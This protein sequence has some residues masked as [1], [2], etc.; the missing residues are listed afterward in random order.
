[1]K[2][3]FVIIL[4]LCS[5]LLT[6]SQKMVFKAAQTSSVKNNIDSTVVMAI[7]NAF[8]QYNLY[9]LDGNSINEFVRNKK[10]VDFR[11]EL[12]N[13]FSWDITLQL[14]D[15]RSPDHKLIVRTENGDEIY[16]ETPAETYLGWANYSADQQVRFSIHDGFLRGFIVQNQEELFIEPVNYFLK[17]APQGLYILYKASDFIRESEISCGIKEVT[18]TIQKLKTEETIRSASCAMTDLAIASDYLFFK[19]MGTVAKANKEILD[20]LN[21]VEAKYMEPSVGIGYNLVATYIVSTNTGDP[22][23]ASTDAYTLLT[24]FKNWGNG[25]GFGTNVTYDLANLWTS[26]DLQAFGNTGV[27]GIG[28]TRPDGNFGVICTPDRYCLM[29]HS[30]SV[31]SAGNWVDQTHECG[32]TWGAIHTIANSTYIMSPSIGPANQTWDQGNI[33]AILAHKNSRTCLVSSCSKGPIADFSA[34]VLTSCDGIVKFSDLTVNNPSSWSWN[35]GD[36]STSTQQNPTHT[37]STNGTYTVKLIVTNSVGSDTLT[38]FSFVQVQKS[39]PP[40]TTDSLRCGPGKIVLSA[41]GSNNGTLNWYT[42]QAGGSPVNTGSSYTVNIS[43]NTTYYVSEIVS[44]P[45]KNTGKPDNLTGGGYF[46]SSL[47]RMYFDVL[48]PCTLKTVKVYTDSAGSRTIEILNNNGQTIQSKT[49][50]IPN[51][52]NGTIITLDMPLSPGTDYAIKLAPNSGQRLYRNNAGPYS[53]PYTIPGVISITNTDATPPNAQNYYY[54]FYEWVIQEPSCVSPMASVTGK[55]DVCTGI[56]D[57]ILENSLEIFPNPGP[58]KFRLSFESVGIEKATME[59]HNMLGQKIYTEI[60][61]G[62]NGKYSEDIDIS[63]YAK[64]IYILKINYSEG[65]EAFRK[66]II[67]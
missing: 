65:K 19:E 35:F 6:F 28:A 44:P 29:E 4:L 1:M 56:N 15:M 18:G 26:R 8:K 55:V 45:Q 53:F 39:T 14:H 11:V 16:P 60:V 27:I 31:G 22:W 13:T 51:A 38:K 46:S 61:S 40:A 59:I 20:V 48:T 49:V 30:F 33:T 43:T 67:R 23:D 34:N 62:S 50:N 7:N 32:H 54:W 12:D 24:S 2:K 21:M 63:K 17:D 64:G 3:H 42:S 10:Q 37:Y 66:L 57:L 47:R 25:G 5:E 36:G 52:P 9:Y 41:S 58:G